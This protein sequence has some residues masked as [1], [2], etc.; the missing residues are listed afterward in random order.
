M[1]KSSAGPVCEFG[2]GAMFRCTR[3]GIKHG[4]SPGMPA[5]AELTWLAC[6]GL[7]PLSVPKA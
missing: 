5:G 6:W 2:K 4:Q 7:L 3:R 1:I